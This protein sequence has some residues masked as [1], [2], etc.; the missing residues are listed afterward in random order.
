MLVGYFLCTIS[1][2]ILY[3]N[4]SKSLFFGINI[5]NYRNKKRGLNSPLTLVNPIFPIKLEGGLE[6]P[7]Y[8]LRMSYSTN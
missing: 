6:P 4:L 8:S 7:T 1:V 5:G 3:K 2:Q